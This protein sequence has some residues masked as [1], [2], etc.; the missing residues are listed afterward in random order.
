[1]YIVYCIILAAGRGTRMGDLT[2][3]CPKPMLK[4]K[5][6]PKLSYSIEML[7]DKITDVV[8][9]V[10][11]L[12]EQ[13]IDFFGNEYAGRKIHYVKQVDFNG[14]AGAV[15]LARE[16]VND[17]FLVI[18]GDDLYYKND[19]EEL[20][21]NNQSIL[22]YKVN[23]AD[24]FGIVE[25]DKNSYLKS[26]I[27]RPHGKKSGLVNTGAYLLSEKY[28]EQ[29]MIAISDTEYGLPQTLAAMYPKIKTKNV[30]ATK[31]QSVG[32]S[33]DLQIAKKRL[34]EFIS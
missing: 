18:M 1:M 27:E 17:R 11:Y 20:L 28:F 34:N 5:N 19:L 3:D 31:W 7:P 13:I 21:H 8:L 32:N 29:Q 30:V 14:T 15:T 16:I 33:N 10:G 6:K 2:S 9:V 22:T 4:I 12:G 23:N 25:V 24:Q 26:I